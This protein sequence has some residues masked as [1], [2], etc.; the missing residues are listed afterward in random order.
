MHFSSNTHSTIL[1][2]VFCIGTCIDTWRASSIGIEVFGALLTLHSEDE[3]PVE[4]SE[5]P[6]SRGSVEQR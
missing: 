1:T 4:V 5:A 2:L 6:G 3:L